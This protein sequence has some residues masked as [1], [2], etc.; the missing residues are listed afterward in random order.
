[1]EELYS[2]KNKLAHD[3]FPMDLDVLEKAILMPEEE[4]YMYG[5]TFEK[6]GERKYPHPG[7]GL[8][9]NPFPKKKKGKKK[10]K[11]KKKK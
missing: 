2:I 1:M 7:M 3:G 9:K 8:M 5:E 11:K 10:K 6:N 4:T